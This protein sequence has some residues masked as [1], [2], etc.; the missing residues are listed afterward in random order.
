MKADMEALLLRRETLDGDP[1]CEGE[2]TSVDKDI[3]ELL[4][5]FGRYEDS[6][7]TSS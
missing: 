2:L 3:D 4:E 1:A 5:A 6:V 7:E